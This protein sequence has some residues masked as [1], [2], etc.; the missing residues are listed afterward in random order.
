[1]VTGKAA[2]GP[3]MA[4]VAA[5]AGVS[6]QTVSR[7]LNN[8]GAVR[9]ETR[10]RV[11]RV[12]SEMGYRRNEAARALASNSSRVLG[13]VT[14]RFVNYGPATTLLT[15]QLAANRK[16]YLVS[17]ATLPEY[18]SKN[19]RKAI[20]DFL[21]LGVAGIIVIVPVEQMAAEL[22]AQTIPVPT[23]A[24][25]SSWI[26]CEPSV[27]RIGVDQRSGVFD[28][29]EHLRSR[30]CQTV[31][32]V[33]GPPDWF[34]ASERE[35]AWADATADL[36][37]TKGPRIQGDWTAASGHK[38]GLD[39][40]G[41][42]LPDAIFVANDQMSLGMLQAFYQQGVRVPEDVLVVGFDDEEG[43]AFFNPA[44]T[45]VRQDFRKMGVEAIERLTEMIEGRPVPS[46]MIPATLK[47]R[48]SA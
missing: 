41:R 16:G 4:D 31:A 17:V 43:S 37:L 5:V 21:S 35:S 40:A 3:S 13:I 48:Q 36:G 10:E 14:P 11:L 29:M 9:P 24:I 6:H 25:A 20:D 39:L 7:V 42:L 38:I 45:T 22:E 28:A 26:N 18:S 47:V 32:H 44:L 33:A 30:G 27:P 46:E 2:R 12:I 34:D 23:L 19:L 15:V 8:K 1:M